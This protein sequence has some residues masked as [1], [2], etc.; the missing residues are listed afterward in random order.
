[1]ILLVEDDAFD[2][3]LALRALANGAGG[4]IAVARDGAEALDYLLPSSGPEPPVPQLVLLDLHLPRVRGL[5]V[6]RRL[7]ATER[8]RRIPVVVLSSSS[9]EG[10]VRRSYELGANSFVC[11]PRDAVHFGEALRTIA[12]YW[13]HLNREST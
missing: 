11:K 6:L 12:R 9:S 8:T 3:A 10:D 7:R 2:E 1:M 5:D 4:P 13:L